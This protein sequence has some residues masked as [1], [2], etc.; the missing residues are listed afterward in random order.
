M[1]MAH[2]FSLVLKFRSRACFGTLL[3][4]HLNCCYRC[5]LRNKGH[6][7]SQKSVSEQITALQAEMRAEM[8]AGTLETQRRFAALEVCALLSHDAVAH[9]S[10]PRAARAVLQSFLGVSRDAAHNAALAGKGFVI[11]ATGMFVAAWC[12]YVSAERCGQ[13]SHRTKQ[14]LARPKCYHHEESSYRRS[15]TQ[16]GP[17]ITALS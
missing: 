2:K 12:V 3:S 8:R 16:G 9:F 6:Q 15:K 7:M 4:L 14:V 10:M 17:S 11:I 1:P 5:Y 13:M